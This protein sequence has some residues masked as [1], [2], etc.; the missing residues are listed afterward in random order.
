[1]VMI[2]KMIKHLTGKNYHQTCINPAGISDSSYTE[3]K[4]RAVDLQNP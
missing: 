3:K 4:I 1:M 2:L